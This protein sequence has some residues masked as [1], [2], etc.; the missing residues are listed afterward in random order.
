MCSSDLLLIPDAVVLLLR[1]LRDDRIPL[2]T[3]GIALASVGYILSPLDLLPEFIFGPIGLI[4][5]LLIDQIA[6]ATA[7]RMVDFGA[8]D[9]VFGLPI[10]AGDLTLNV[11]REG[12]EVRGANTVTVSRGRIVYKD[13]ELRTE[14]GAGRYVDRP[15]FAEYYDAL[16]TKRAFEKPTPVKREAVA[17]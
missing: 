16:K 1:L 9:V 15:P 7:S 3:K 17:A 13:G 14:R 10:G 12:M 6:V 2:G 4:D 11:N 8:E 5:D